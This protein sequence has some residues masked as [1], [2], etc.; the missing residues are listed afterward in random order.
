MNYLG[1]MNECQMTC[2]VVNIKSLQD[3]QKILLEVG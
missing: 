1:A 3:Y 2:S